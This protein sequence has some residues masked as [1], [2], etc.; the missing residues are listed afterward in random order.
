MV[1]GLL[2]VYNALSINEL[3]KKSEKLREQIRLNNSMIT[4]QKLTADE[5]QSIHNIEQEALLL[6]LE[7]SHEPPIEIER[8][9]EP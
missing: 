7:A 6:G 8:T 2:Q 1:L 3:A 5:L 4:T 9:I